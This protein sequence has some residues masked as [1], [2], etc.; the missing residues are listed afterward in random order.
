MVG[1][2]LVV[3]DAS[4]ECFEGTMLEPCL[5]KL[6]FHVAGSKI[7]VNNKFCCNTIAIS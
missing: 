6:C 7:N 5:L 3:H 1:V 4:C 2:N